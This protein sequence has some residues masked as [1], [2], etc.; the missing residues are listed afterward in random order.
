MNGRVYDP[1]VARFLSADP[2][3]QDPEHS[4]SYNRYSYVWNNPTNLTDPTGFKTISTSVGGVTIEHDAGTV[5]SCP[6]TSSCFQDNDGNIHVI[7]S[8]SWTDTKGNNTSLDFTGGAG[9]KA[10]SAATKVSANSGYA[11]AKGAMPTAGAELGQTNFGEIGTQFYRRAMAN[12]ADN[13]RGDF[14]FWGWAAEKVDNNFDRPNT[15]SAE[16]KS[17]SI[18]LLGLALRT[19][20]GGK[21]E[22]AAELAHSKEFSGALNKAMV[23]LEERGFKAEQQTL[24]KFGPNAGKPIGMQTADGKIGFRVEYDARNGGHINVWSGKEKGPH[25]TFG[26]NQ[27]SVDRIVR[28]FG[29]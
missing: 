7:S 9:A 10:T 29:Q 23:W 4:Q 11:A 3:I 16:G 2:L 28:L 22:V 12:F 26:G 20:G 19:P 27:S 8:I 24:G 15:E 25:Y 1:L 17:A 13:N 6:K 14:G 18:L 5:A 21:G